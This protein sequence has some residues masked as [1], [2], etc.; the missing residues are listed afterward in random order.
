MQGA[1]A[2]GGPAA[3]RTG[4]FT[5][6]PGW[7]PC[8]WGCRGAGRTARSRR[9]RRRCPRS[10]TR[11]RRPGGAAAVRARRGHP[12]PRPR[13]AA[14]RCARPRR[15]EGRPGAAH[16]LLEGGGLLQVA[17]QGE[18]AERLPGRLV[19]LDLHGAALHG[20]LVADGAAGHQ[21]R[22]GEALQALRAH[23]DT[24]RLPPE[25]PTRT[26]LPG[27]RAG[28]SPSCR[29]AAAAGAAS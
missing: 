25:P 4:R 24:A 12:L 28:R 17:L 16:Q 3:G 13:P 23:G 27:G 26:S 29:C 20:A 19:G 5:C 6:R 8:C 7:V 18:L 15:P 2:C 11:R 22:P 10:R 9:C 1:Q 21:R 14:P